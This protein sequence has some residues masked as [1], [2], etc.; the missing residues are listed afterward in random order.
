MS[1]SAIS[2]DV[3]VIGGGIAGAS[4][5]YWLARDGCRV[6]LMEREDQP[7]YHSSGRSAA[8][9]SETYGPPA[10]RRL[11]RASR[12]FLDAPPDGFGDHPLLTPRGLMFLAEPGHEAAVEAFAAEARAGGAR[13]EVLDEAGFRDIVPILRP[14]AFGRAALEPEAMDLDVHALLQGFLRGMKAAGG[15][16]ETRAEVCG[17]SFDGGVWRLETRAGTSFTAPVV[18]NAAGAWADVVAEIAGVPSL[19]LVPMRRT[20][21]MLDLPPGVD[22]RGWPLT[23]DL[24]DQFYIKPDAGRLILS[25][26]DATPVPPQDVR[27][28]LLDIARAVD[29]VT[30]VT[31]LTVERPGETWAGLRTFAADHDPVAGVA[32]TAP[33]FFWLAG[34]GGYGLMTAPGLGRLAAALIQGKEVPA[35]IEALGLSTRDLAP[36]RPGLRDGVTWASRQQAEARA[37]EAADAG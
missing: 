25:P 10:I 11:A 5:G 30:R 36:D 19:G 32:P 37:R 20:A 28:E 35:D 15:R 27:P 8:L 22:A 9:F 7:G 17:L 1:Q 18:V 12:A 26:A 2:A 6:C 33:G 16:I 14:G 29:R 4:V 21:I 23:A 24:T 34:Q 31:T 13:V 3:L